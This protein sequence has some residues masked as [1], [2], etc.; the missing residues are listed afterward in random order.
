MDRGNT[1]RWLTIPLLL[2]A[3]VLASCKQAEEPKVAEKKAPVKVILVEAQLPP[4][5][6]KPPLPPLFSDIERRTFQF[7]WDT[8][9]EVNGLSP[10]RFPSRPFASIASVGFA[11]TAY[12]IGIENGWVS[13]NQAIDRTLTTLKFF[14]DAPMG[15]QKTGRAGYKGFYYHFLDM[16]QGNRY[17]S[18]VELSSVDTALLM[19][20]VLFTQSYYDGDD[21]REKEIRQIA[22]TLYKRVDWRW[23][24]QR[25]PLISMGWFPESGFINHDWMGYN[26]AMM[27]YILA[28]GSPTHGVDPDAWTSWTRTYNNDWGVYQG[29]E[30]LSFGPL[31][32]HQYSHVW[33][34][35]RDIQDQYMRERGIDYFLNSRRATLAQ[36]D[37]AID[38]PMKWKDYGENVW[39]LTASDGPQNT[40]QEYR[41][42]QRQFRHYSSRGAGLRENFDDGTIAPTAAISSIVFAP[43]V[44]I[45]ATQEMHKRYGD[46]LYSSYGFLDSFNPS[47]NYDIPI[48]TGRMV[49][50]RGWVASDYIAIDQGPI[51]TMIANY[52]NEFVWNVMKKNPYIRAGL[53]RAGFTGGW[54]TPEGEPQPAPQK[55]EQKA[56][57]RALGM[58]ESRAAAAQ[59][60]QDPS[61]RQKPE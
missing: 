50:D 31:F 13:R 49:P 42:E 54:L 35:F 11:L 36:R 23:L 29:Q 6:V 22:D 17:D 53:E 18:W 47:F 7:F 48:K 44:V 55:D 16:Q 4:K 34:D 12:P 43:E 15:P 25:A 57:A 19:M 27:L 60:Q 58:A 52:Q 14:R 41:G 46:F 8:T 10:D 40:S 30:Y 28:L 32:G 1:S 38:N 26:E 61:Q 5:P 59:A 45:P 3:L 56:A 37:Y 20:G 9:N 21:P 33:I 51:L 2:G 24:Q 39:G